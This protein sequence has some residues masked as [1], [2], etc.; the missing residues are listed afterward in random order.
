MRGWV[1]R[2]Y[3]WLATLVLVY[4]PALVYF[5]V[6]LAVPP[7]AVAQDIPDIVSRNLR[8]LKSKNANV[9]AQAAVALGDYSSPG[10]P[11]NDREQTRKA[12]PALVDA[13]K[14]TDESVR[15]AAAFALGNIP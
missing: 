7:N 9:R 2:K 1:F 14:D 10:S 4:F 8:D 13:L 11:A 6:T 15:E 5:A 12:I 3:P